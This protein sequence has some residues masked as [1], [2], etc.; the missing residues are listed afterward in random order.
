MSVGKTQSQIIR[1]SW[2]LLGGGMR[3]AV[4]VSDV[5]AVVGAFSMVSFPFVMGRV[6]ISAREARIAIRTSSST[7]SALMAM[8]AADPSPAAVI[9]CA[10]GL[11][12]L[13]AAQT[14]GTLVS[15]SAPVIAQP[16]S[17]TIAAEPDEQV[18]VRHESRRHEERVARNHPT[19]GELDALQ[20][21]VVHD[22]A[23]HVA[24][25]DR[26]RPGRQSLAL[27]GAQAP[28]RREVREVVAPLPHDQRVLRLPAAEPPSTAS[29]ASLTSKPW[30]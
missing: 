12:T 29:V 26:D 25:D 24:L 16:S 18:V 2:C 30:Q 14:P 28:G 21:I 27:G 7:R 19:V 9:T 22:D 4:S 3:L 20:A 11:A 10:R 8:A 1:A 6:L 15:P 17:S 23:L 5:G 13:P